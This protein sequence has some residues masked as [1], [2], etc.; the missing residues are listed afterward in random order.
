MTGKSIIEQVP[1]SLKQTIESE[2]GVALEVRGPGVQQ[3]VSQ[4][5]LAARQE[6]TALARMMNTV[7]PIGEWLGLVKK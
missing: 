3:I 2:G 4:E 6:L 1:T 5:E 7:R